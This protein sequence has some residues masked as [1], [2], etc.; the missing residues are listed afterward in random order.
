MTDHTH[1]SKNVDQTS[2]IR[3]LVHLAHLHQSDTEGLMNLHT[4]DTLIVN[5]AGRRILG[6]DAFKHA[7]DQ[8]LRGQLSKVTTTTQVDDIRFVTPDVAIVSCTKYVV[9]ERETS[10]KGTLPDR[11]CLTYVVVSDAREWKIASAQTTPVKGPEVS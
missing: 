8:A 5:I 4:R 1:A 7:M 11:G 10:L 3:E 2:S 6:R 9:D